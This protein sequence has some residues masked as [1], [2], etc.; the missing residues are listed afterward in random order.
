VHITQG[1]ENNGQAVGKTCIAPGLSRLGACGLG[2]F[3]ACQNEA[4]T[5]KSWNFSITEGHV[6]AVVAEDSGWPELDLVGGH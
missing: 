4:R 5:S 2:A 6:T 1:L 3:V